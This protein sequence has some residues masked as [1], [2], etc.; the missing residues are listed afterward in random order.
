MC[1]VLSRDLG[2]NAAAVGEARQVVAAALARWGL[3]ELAPDAELLVSELVT[4]AVLHARTD[5]ALTVAVADGT[6]EVGITDRS[7]EVPLPRRGDDPTATPAGP[8]SAVDW[9]AEGGRGLRLVDLISDEW[10]VATLAGGKQVWFR[11]AVDAEWP[12]RSDCPCGG[13]ELERVRLE[14]GR[15]AAARPGPW[16]RD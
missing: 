2:R 9:W 8:R 10:G 3:S 15:F 4:N 14:S 11:L 12:H 6:L 16:D 1:R 5:V 13:E 7:P